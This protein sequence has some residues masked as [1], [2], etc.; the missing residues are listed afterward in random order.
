M[1]I[2]VWHT[3]QCGCKIK[4]QFKQCNLMYDQESSLR[5]QVTQKQNRD[6][7]NY[8]SKHMPKVG[9]ATTE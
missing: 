3:Y 6:P 4:G 8:C 5:C 7:R 9:K 1:C 2:Q